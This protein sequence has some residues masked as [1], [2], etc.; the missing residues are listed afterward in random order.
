MSLASDNRWWATLDPWIAAA[1]CV[2][3]ALYASLA[4]KAARNGLARLGARRAAAAL[5]V[6]ALLPYLLYAPATGAFDPAR[7]LALTFLAALASFWYAALPRRRA[8]DAAFLVLIAAVVLAKVWN[9]VYARPSNWPPMETL[10]QLMWIRVGVGSALAIRHAEGVGFGWLPTQREW[11]IGA[12]HFLAF[13]PLGLLLG[14]ATGFIRGLGWQGPIWREAL[15]A[16]ATFLGMLWVVAL[17]EEF[18]FRG[19]LQR[20]LSEWSGSQRIG[21]L[22][23]S[24]LFGAAHLPFR[25]F[26]NW[27]F[28]LLATLAGLFYGRAYLAGGGIRAAMVAHALTN[29]L[30]RAVLR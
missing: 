16:V 9:H 29:T 22:V 5:T 27:R 26:P 10:G 11:R 1:W 20:W 6:S 25:G 19:L 13:L 24:V 2:E 8:A 30:W 28:A 23:A 7:F 3:L 14:W 17:G 12:L 18:F 4:W 15:V 21:W